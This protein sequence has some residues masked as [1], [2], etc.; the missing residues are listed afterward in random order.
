MLAVLSVLAL[1]AP[2]PALAAAPCQPGTW[3]ESTPSV[4]TSNVSGANVRLDMYH[5]F[6]GGPSWVDAT[7]DYSGVSY[8]AAVVAALTAFPVVD[9]PGPIVVA[10]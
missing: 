2:G 8:L 7:I 1:S 10:G 3:T 9:T 4:A 6:Q 5:K